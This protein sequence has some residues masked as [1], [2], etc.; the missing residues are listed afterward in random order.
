M[1]NGQSAS[2]SWNKAPIWGVR[3]DIYYFLTISVSAF[4]ERPL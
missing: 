4:V 1:T 3:P 2:L